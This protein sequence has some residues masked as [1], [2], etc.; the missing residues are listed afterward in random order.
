MA[1]SIARF[2]M[3]LNF[4][5]LIQL[6][7]R[8]LYPEP[9]VFVREL[10]QNAHDAIERRLQ[11]DDELAGRI[12]I[13]ISRNRTIV[14]RDNGI[15]MSEDDIRRFLS[16]IGS[17]GTLDALQKMEA[18]GREGAQRLIGQFGIGFLS[19]FLVAKRVEVRTRKA[20]TDRALRWQNDGSLDCEL[21]DDEMS[22]PGT[23][24]TVLV[25]DNYGYFLDERRLTQVIMKYCDFIPFPIMLNGNGPI[26]ELDIPF[27]RSHWNSDE[28]KVA[29]YE[30]FVRRRYSDTPLDVIPVDIDEEHSARGVLM[31]TDRSI[32]D[33][34]TSGVMDILI[35]R[36]FIKPEDTNLLP[37]WAK[38]VR[39]VIDSPSLEP[40]A[41]RDNYK[42]DHPSV[43]FLS[44]KL[45]EIIVNRLMY[46]SKNEPQ[47]FKQINQ[48][49]H[50]HLKGMACVYDDFFKQV[51]GLLLF[52]TN[53]GLM[54]LDT[55]LTKNSSRP[56]FG[57]R[58]P[59]YYFSHSGAAT[60]F[61]R[62]ADARGW[63]VIDAGWIFEVDFL[64]KYA[65]QNPA[66]TVLVRLDTTD[67]PLMFQP[68]PVSEEEKFRGLLS[69]MQGHLT[70]IGLQHVRVRMRRFQPPEIPAVVLGSMKMEQ[71]EKIRDIL[72]RAALS[73]SVGDI[74]EEVLSDTEEA[75]LFVNLNADNRLI[76][77]LSDLNRQTPTV[78]SILTGIYNCAMVHSH[79]LLTENNTRVMHDQF[80]ELLE[81]LLNAQE[82]L[83]SARHE[84]E[85]ERQQI[86]QYRDRDS[87]ADSR[88]PEHIRLFM[89]APFDAEYMVLE[90][91]IREIFET[92]PYYF[93]IQ[94]AR[95][96]VFGPSLL[97]NIKEH[98]GRAHGF[99]AE[100]S[101]L[102][103]NVMFELG[104]VMLAGDD[105]PVFTLRSRNAEK[106]VPADLREKLRIEYD[107]VKD[108]VDRLVSDIRN[109][110]EREGRI[111]HDQIRSLLAARKKRF[112]SRKLLESTMVKLQPAHTES[113][114][115]HYSTV[116]DF[117][118]TDPSL[119]SRQTGV[120][121]FL[122]PAIRGE[123][124]SKTS[125]IQ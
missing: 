93:E 11:N 66:T 63:T 123:L 19:A 75:P 84:L 2:S 79:N 94:L 28:E 51:A 60:Q 109:G 65:E 116:E 35:R 106:D 7:A 112:L 46:L 121:D 90:G 12:D 39:G 124:N 108:S 110:L 45:G 88:R 72:R 86:I 13:S 70:Q 55:Y 29:R 105:R 41:S 78:Q 85:Q 64:R 100:I 21:Y 16:V 15:G 115:R 34:Q 68:L 62:L 125:P 67:D 101:T 59:I 118:A 113:I 20:G 26:N 73:S 25:D 48:W 97:E 117:L 77:K 9:D 6:L 95:D 49:H 27:Y 82:S 3:G 96:Y 24:V 80:L 36:M 83:V 104:A 37:P 89:M 43:A 17:S 99:I 18:E 103:A 56:D 91:A 50:W 52:K 111:I 42:G 58:A 122:L 10:V 38:F 87:A 5:G 98:I 57:N 76:R 44:R 14:F 1:S 71:E 81:N 23:E 32:P 74:L 22:Q 31:I 4:G 47:R 69:D 40:T 114:M 33:I 53:Q 54:S 107:S 92:H 30:M 102:N 120:P 61:K 8:H 119:V